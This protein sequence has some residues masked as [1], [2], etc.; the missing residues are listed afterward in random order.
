HAGR[1]SP[2]ARMSL[3]Q[4]AAAFPSR[5]PDETG[6]HCVFTLRWSGEASLTVR[7]PPAAATA[8]PLLSLPSARRRTGGAPGRDWPNPV[9]I[10][11]LPLALPAPSATDPGDGQVS[12][13][14]SAFGD[15]RW[16]LRCPPRLVLLSDAGFRQG[17]RDHCA[18][19]GRERRRPPDRKRCAVGRDT[20]SDARH[21]GAGAGWVPGLL[22]C[23]LSHLEW[24]VSVGGRA[25]NCWPG[26][27][28]SD[29]PRP[30][31]L[32]QPLP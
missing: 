4:R 28:Q 7:N 21:A 12:A 19:P 14:L 20:R 9:G 3:R 30:P 2:A 1:C 24:Q 32:V 13:G 15:P 23:L 29:E 25:G 8:L 5:R 22:L 17:R 6:G 27:D 18:G 26:T 31:R 11:P 10:V 16:R